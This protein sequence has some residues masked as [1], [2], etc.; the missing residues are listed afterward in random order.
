MLRVQESAGHGVQREE[1]PDSARDR[2]LVRVVM[3]GEVSV[4]A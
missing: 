4:G 1:G 3:E 2:F